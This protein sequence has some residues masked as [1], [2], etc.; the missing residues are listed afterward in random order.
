MENE[1]YLGDGVYAKLDGNEIELW[2]E[3]TENGRN[4]IVLGRAE[5]SNLMVFLQTKG[6][7]LL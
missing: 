3:R 6:E 4:W 1:I 5:V 2:T 7:H